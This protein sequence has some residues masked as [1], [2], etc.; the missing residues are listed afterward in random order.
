MSLIALGSAKGAPGVS[1][2]AVALAG[3]AGPAGVVADLDPFGGDLALRYRTPDGAP[4]DTERGLLSLAAANR[5]DQ[6]DPASGAGRL[7]EHLQTAAGGLRMLLGISAPEQAAGLRPL[8]PALAT[9]LRTAGLAGGPDGGPARVFADCG[10]I[11]PGTPVLPVL[12]EADAVLLVA[13]ADL[14]ELAHLRERLRFL[15]GMLPGRMARPGLPGRL[16]VVL[17]AQERARGL[18][19]RTEQLLQAAGLPVPVV[20]V[21]ADDPR[22]AAVLRGARAGSA[23]RS[24]LV[25]SARGLLPAVLQLAGA[26]AGHPAPSAPARSD[27]APSAAV[28]VEG[29]R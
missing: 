3:I 13:R 9:A 23:G 25:R 12:A 14:E 28:A 27:P 5:G 26:G 7:V 17:V 6:V 10:R 19:S 21:L 18:G 16:G 22:G 11:A 8:W 29:A 20:G 24:T 15:S 4:L 1:T 2:L